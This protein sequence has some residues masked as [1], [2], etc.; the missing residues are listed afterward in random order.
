MLLA[1]LVPLALDGLP[2]HDVAM[3]IHES[4]LQCSG[5]A[6]VDLLRKNGAMRDKLHGEDL[7]RVVV[8][9]ARDGYRV[10]FSLGELDA[11]RGKREAYV[12]DRCDGKPLDD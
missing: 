6:L 10:V 7:R 9:D 1:A 12:V 8:L 3:T 4:K 2:R 11:T 5:V